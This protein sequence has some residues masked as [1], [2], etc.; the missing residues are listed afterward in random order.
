MRQS[1]IAGRE[2][3][4]RATLTLVSGKSTGAPQKTTPCQDCALLTM[5]RHDRFISAQTLMAWMRNLYGMRAGWKTINNRLL[6]CGYRAYRPT[7]KTLLTANHC[8]LRLEWAQRWQNLIMAHWQHDIFSESRFQLYP[9]DDR[10]R[11]RRLPGECFQQRC[12]ANRVQAGGGSVHV[13]EAYHSG[14]QSPLVLPDEY[15]TSELYRGIL[16]NTLVSFD[17]RHLGITII[18]KTI[19]PHL[20]VLM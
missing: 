7:R 20:T 6:P 12:Q 1:D 15:L 4:T 3:L 5:V 2:G 17:R 10:L 13:W 16:G 11:V 9:V 19:T 18:T 8:G 14:A